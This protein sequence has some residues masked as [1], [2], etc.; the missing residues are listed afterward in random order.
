ML[1]LGPIKNDSFSS[2]KSGREEYIAP[3]LEVLQLAYDN[4]GGGAG[5]GS[6]EQLPSEAKNPFEP[7]NGYDF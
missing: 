7:D 1:A 5:G 4:A 6:N 3:E 2:G